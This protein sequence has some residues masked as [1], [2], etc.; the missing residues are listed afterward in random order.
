MPESKTIVIS[1]DDYQ[2]YIRRDEKMSLIEKEIKKA[3]EKKVFIDA[4]E[5]LKY[6][7][8]EVSA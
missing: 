7:E 5:L 3:L 1:V 4:E 8:L 6:F 2:Y